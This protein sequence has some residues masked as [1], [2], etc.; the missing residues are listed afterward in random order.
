MKTHKVFL[1]IIKILYV[2]L[3][4]QESFFLYHLILEYKE[5]SGI[6]FPAIFILI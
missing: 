6:T 4:K 1:D 5:N 2:N 3:L